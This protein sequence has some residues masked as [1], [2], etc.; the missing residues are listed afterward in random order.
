MFPLCRPLLV[1][2]PPFSYLLSTCALFTSRGQTQV[3]KKDISE[4]ELWGFGFVCLP[5]CFVVLVDDDDDVFIYLGK[6]KNIVLKANDLGFYEL[7]FL[8]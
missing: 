4:V 5:V 7:G 8:M 1:F 3:R 2:L 6:K